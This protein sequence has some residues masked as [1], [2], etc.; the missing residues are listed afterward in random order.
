[1][2][3]IPTYAAGRPQAWFRAL[4]R[5]WLLRRVTSAPA[6]GALRAI[7]IMAAAWLGAWTVIDRWQSQPDP[8]F[9]AGGIPLLAWYALAILGLAALLRSRAQP[10]P[11]FKPV[12]ALTL[13]AVPV[14]L[15][16]TS[17]AGAY[18]SPSWFLG[19]AV[20]VAVYT[21]T[22]LARGLH[23]VTGKSQRAA[24]LA[25]LGFIIL[26]GWAT[27]AL[28]VIPDVW[29]SRETQSAAAGEAPADGE[30]LLFD[31]AARIDRLLAAMGGG[32]SPRAGAP[33]NADTPPGSR[34]FFLGFAGVGD[35][36][37]FAQ[38]IGLAS[39]VLGE[40]YDIGPRS[41]SLI[42]DER[43]LAR[44]PLAT[45]SGLR[46][47]LRGLGARMNVDR[48]VLFLAI[49][50]HGA[51]DPAIIVDNSQL[52]LDDMTDEDLVDALQESGIKWRVIIISA[53]YA[54]GFIDSLRNPQTIVITA[55]AADRTS[56]GC[57]NDRDLTYFG[58]AFYR[59]ALPAAHSLREAFITAKAAIA[60]RERAEHITP[61]EPQGYFGTEMDAKL[62][63][64]SAPAD[65]AA[66]AARQARAPAPGAASRFFIVNDDGQHAYGH[67]AQGLGAVRHVTAKSQ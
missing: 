47:A 5:L 58:E 12:L 56:F 44:A 35:E 19:A 61:S 3:E 65:N 46:Y 54:G 9:F 25:G 27:D 42:N 59:D 60:A 33:P 31:Q 40:R 8:Q 24:A 55:A 23:A 52:P 26:F 53:C 29:A 32:T 2:S 49:S 17:V 50:S 41:L 28:D 43:D 48:D 38:E 64:M 7:V 62:A 11:D 10:A 63:A 67:L 6:A 57:S 4:G 13:G 16:F 39:R 21:L 30:A 22:Y 66:P 34:A 20:V 51:E 15:L 14:P 36:K 18:L 37:V 1:M 45:V